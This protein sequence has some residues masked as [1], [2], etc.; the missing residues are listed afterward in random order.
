LWVEKKSIEDIATIRVLTKQTIYSHF[1]KLIQTKAVSISEV[2]P[3]DKMQDL[4][5]AFAGYKEESLNTM[6]EKYGHKFSWEE[7]RM[8]KASLN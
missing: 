1:V 7:A 8:Y 3:E 5:I 2:L 6:M 4:A